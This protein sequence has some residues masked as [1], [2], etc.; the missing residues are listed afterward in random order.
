MAVLDEV[1]LGLGA[2]RIARQPALLAKRGEHRLAS[3]DELVHVGLVSGVPQDGVARA[4]EDP[5]QGQRQLDR[6]E[7]RAQVA[8]RLGHRLHDEVAD[9]AGEVVELGVGEAAQVGRLLD[10][11]QDHGHRDQKHRRDGRPSVALHMRTSGSPRE[12][13]TGGQV[14]SPLVGDLFDLSGHVALVTGGN[15]GIGLGM[16]EGLAAHG[17]DVAIWG[18]NESKNSAA[19]EQLAQHGTRVLG[20][21]VRRR[22]R[23]GGRGVVRGDPRCARKGRLVLRERRASA[24]AATS[25]SSCRPRT[26]TRCCA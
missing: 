9:L 5:V 21:Q 11:L 23:G 16:A 6:A 20:P 24:A 15:S 26:G 3:G 8:G 22:R 14:W 7:V 13:T 1:V 2:R 4:V 12:V 10:G 18:T 17:A 19:A 25:S